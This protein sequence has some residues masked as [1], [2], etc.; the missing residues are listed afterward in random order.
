MQTLEFNKLMVL[1]SFNR[2]GIAEKD[3]EKE[4]A[5]FAAIEVDTPE[6]KCTKDV[7][8]CGL[9]QRGTLSYDQVP[10]RQREY[11]QR[12]IY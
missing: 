12:Q 7:L 6:N 11:T 9:L 4:G 5:S 3:A 8:L 2:V 10:W 1:I